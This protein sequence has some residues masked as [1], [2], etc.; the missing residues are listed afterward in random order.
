MPNAQDS[1]S[2]PKGPVESAHTTRRQKL[3]DTLSVVCLDA[4]P[5]ASVTMLEAVIPLPIE[6]CT[7]CVF[8]R[9]DERKARWAKWRIVVTSRASH[10]RH[11]SYACDMH[12]LEVLRLA[13]AR[14]ASEERQMSLFDA[15]GHPA[16]DEPSFLLEDV[17]SVS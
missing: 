5:G 7:R 1:R 8:V 4:P 14:R 13:L 10:A 15:Y 6:R 11:D 9:G 2:Q 16:V 12:V 3:I 17:L